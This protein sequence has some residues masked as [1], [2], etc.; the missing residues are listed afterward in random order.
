MKMPGRTKTGKERGDSGFNVSERLRSFSPS[1]LAPCPSASILSSL[2]IGGSPLSGS[3]HRP[4]SDLRGAR[5]A[6]IRY[7]LTFHAPPCPSSTKD[8][9]TSNAPQIILFGKQ[10]N[11]HNSLSFK[12]LL[13]S[14]LRI[15][16][17]KK[18]PLFCNIPIC[19]YFATLLSTVCVSKTDVLI[20]PKHNVILKMHFQTTYTMTVNYIPQ[21]LNLLNAL[22]NSVF[23]YCIYGHPSG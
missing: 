8:G 14:Q 19:Q 7:I 20:Y 5:P 2:P 3:V 21:S 12:I 15:T 1:I 11:P 17:K 10:T 4:P 16:G 13:R 18:Y 22:K 9:R 23:T 6:G